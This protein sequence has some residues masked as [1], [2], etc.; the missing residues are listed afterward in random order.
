MEL[1]LLKCISLL[2]LFCLCS[3]EINSNSISKK[4]SKYAILNQ[5]KAN[6]SAATT[7]PTTTSSTPSPTTTQDPFFSDDT[8]IFA[9]FDDAFDGTNTQKMKHR[10]NI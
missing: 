2:F 1:S 3:G 10:L 4:G 8:D 9:D 6:I 7:V 5:R